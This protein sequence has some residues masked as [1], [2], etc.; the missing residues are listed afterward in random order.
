VPNYQNSSPYFDDANEA[1]SKDY[2]QI[3]FRPGFAVQGR[4]LTQLQSLLQY[5]I[6]QM[7]DFLFTDGSPVVGG[8]ITFDNTV[9][10]LLIQANDNISLSDFAGTLLINSVGPVTTRAVCISVD[11]TVSS[12]TVEGAL[13]VKYLSGFEFNPGDTLQIATNTTETA[14]LLTSNAVTKG[15]IVSIN[16]G[17]FYVSGYFVAV[18]KQTIVL[19][20]EDQFP[21]YRVGLEIDDSIID[22]ST[23]STLLDPAQS[24]FNYQ[25]PGATRYQYKLVLAK[26]LLNS[27]DDSKFFELLRIENGVITSQVEYP[28]L[29]NIE[30]VLARRTYDQSGN[31]TVDPFIASTVDD[32]S[33]ANN[34]IVSVGPGNAYIEG[35]QF[36]TIAPV[37]LNNPKARSTNTATD[38][39]L[40]LEFGNYVTVTNLFSGNTT[41]FATDNFGQV[42]LH[43]VSSSSINTANVQSYG[44]TKIGTARVRDIEFDGTNTW[45]AYLLDVTLTPIVI[46]ANG[47]SANTTSIRLPQSFT[48][49]TNAFAN[50]TMTVLSGNSSGDIRTIVSYDSVNKIGFLD[51][52]TTQLLDSTSNV[53]INFGIKDIDALVAHPT[54]VAA[55]VFGTQNTTSALF[56][57]MDISVQGKDASGN[58]ILFNTNFNR[59]DFELPQNY[60]AQNSFSNVTFT[61]RKTLDTVQFTSG[62]TTIGTGSGLGT[63]EQFTFG[64][65]NQYLP[66]TIS[67]N[68]FFVVV[69]DK[70][71]SNLANGQVIT[72]D[73][74][75]NPAGNGVY[76]T[77]STH[78]T[79]KTVTTGNFLGDIL[80]TVQDTNASVNFRR[81]KTLIG[82][83]SNTTLLT[84]DKYINGQAV[85]GTTNANSHYIDAANGYVWFTNWND[86]KK[87]PGQKQGLAL[88]DV[89]QI[90]KIYDSGSPSQAPNT[91][92][93]ID[94]TDRYLFDSGQRD[95]YYDHGGIILRDG[96][97]PPVG[98]TVVILQYYS[99][100]STTGF[101]S[102]DS[103]SASAYANGSIQVYSSERF[104]A[105]SLRDTIDFRPTRTIGTT[106]NIQSLNLTGLR[107]PQPDNAMTLSYAYYLPR[108]DKLAITASKQ[109]QIIQGTPALVPQVPADAPDSM[110]IYVINVPAYTSSA[111]LVAM[112]YIEN[113][114]YTMSDIG[115]LD[116]R[117][118]Q[119]EYYVSLSQLEQQTMQQT[120]LYQ[121][122]TTAKEQY[123][124]VTDSFVDFSV[125]DSSNPDL[126]CN[127]NNGILGPYIQANPIGFMFSSATGPAQTND[128]TYSL[129]YSETPCIVQNTASDFTQVQPYAF[130]QFRGDVYLYPQSDFWYSDDLVPQIIGPPVEPA[131]P[132]APAPVV[133]P[134]TT[135][136]TTDKNNANLTP[137]TTTT[138]APAPTPPAA[139]ATQPAAPTQFTYCY[140]LNNWFYGYNFLNY[141]YLS[142]VGIGYGIGGVWYYG[143]Y[144]VRIRKTPTGYGIMIPDG[145]WY[146]VPAAGVQAITNLIASGAA[147]PVNSTVGNGIVLSAHSSIGAINRFL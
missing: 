116:R 68:N 69:R 3:L 33:N 80:V 124:I 120:V 118:Q 101:F 72:W 133:P 56:A 10:S 96:Q 66:D 6:S 13:V 106:A 111:S 139:G 109:F 23:D 89:V 21:S 79:L 44:N 138:T 24:S 102:A 129:S 52:A 50:V 95:N 107:L 140:P 77:D 143:S 75:S 25:A 88:A 100:D 98:Q 130:G 86:I 137:T 83:T 15:S 16:D 5:Q 31:F 97:A 84:T 57:C 78:V 94:I 1:I 146:T 123:G 7:G 135:G 73:L 17:V 132:P 60:I 142:S 92:N 122:G 39:Q 45:L 112:Q 67:R 47:V 74:G 127:I 9:T 105:T 119:L 76:Q 125:A 121:D 59:L 41:G 90:I 38:F 110:T 70:Q 51:R 37:K 26:R 91:I 136:A 29:G 28:V 61:N 65:S 27:T 64:F 82:N 62:N 147:A 48:G 104:G 145:Y 55:N 8:H 46:N 103:Y 34:M 12:N 22:E 54:V 36:Q 115:A 19:D 128:R 144:C 99:H 113:K 131:P 40:S 42:D 81:T 63:A 49:T 43:I 85:I 32:A 14:S 53:S 87:V 35:F 134:S 114:R 20:S 108:I 117:I 58:T 93:S 11:D 18:S 30:Q 4:E 141:T 71:T 126:F 2:V